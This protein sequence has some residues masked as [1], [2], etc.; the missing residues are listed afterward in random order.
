MLRAASDAAGG[1]VTRGAEHA[2][3]RAPD[4]VHVLGA[5]G[6]EVQ[7]EAPEAAFV[8]AL[9][10]LQQ[11]SRCGNR[12]HHG[13]VVPVPVARVSLASLLGERQRRL[14]ARQ[15]VAERVARRSVRVVQRLAPRVHPGRLLPRQ[16]VHRGAQ[17]ARQ[18]VPRDRSLEAQRP[19]RHRPMMVA[20]VSSRPQSVTSSWPADVPLRR[21]AASAA[22]SSPVPRRRP[23]PRPARPAAWPR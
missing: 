6:L 12:E 20:S 5:R 19:V 16:R 18:L 21:P 1:A 13:P 11:H 9:A 3:Q 4:G 10:R 8:A 15:R 2:A 23:P 22:P 14:G 17:R 7:V